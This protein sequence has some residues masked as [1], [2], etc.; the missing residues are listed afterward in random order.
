LDRSSPSCISATTRK[1]TNQTSAAR[2]AWPNGPLLTWNDDAST[3]ILDRYNSEHTCSATAFI[4]PK[5]ASN[6]LGCLII[7]PRIEHKHTTFLNDFRETS[8]SKDLHK[9]KADQLGAQANLFHRIPFLSDGGLYF[10]TL[11]CR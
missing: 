7:V 4:I 9:N 3:N 1:T 2:Q 11:D 8:A 6:R 10:K 5:Q